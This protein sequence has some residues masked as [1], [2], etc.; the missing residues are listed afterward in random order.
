MFRKMHRPPMCTW[1]LKRT[2]KT[3]I[4]NETIEHP[5]YSHQLDESWIGVTFTQRAE[6]VKLRKLADVK[7]CVRFEDNASIARVHVKHLLGA[8]YHW[9]IALGVAF[10]AGDVRRGEK[11]A[12]KERPIHCDRIRQAIE[13]QMR[14]QTGEGIALRAGEFGSWRVRVGIAAEKINDGLVDDILCADACVIS[15]II[16]E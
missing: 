3:L 8:L 7:Q 5:C 14:K 2:P 15:A 4:Q 16:S 6:R 11:A 13:M 10:S 1:V 9:R 12:A